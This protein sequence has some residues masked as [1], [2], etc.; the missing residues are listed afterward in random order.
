MSKQKTI[1]LV[2]LAL[3]ASL[4]VSVYIYFRPGKVNREVQDSQGSVKESFSKDE[5]KADVLYED[6]VVGFSMQHPASITIED[7]TPE[8]GLFYTL[9]S[10]NRED[11]MMTVAFKKTEYESVVEMLE[12]D[13]EAPQE[14][15]LIGATS[16]DGIPANQYS[17][18]FKGRDTLL[19]AAIDEGVLFL[20]EGPKD[21]GFWEETQNIVVSTFAFDKNQPSSTS[22]SGQPVIYEAE[23]VI[24]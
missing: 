17:Y 21:E 4:G 9:L 12:K 2:A 14:T 13:P 23:E 19:S 10:L 24:E 1:I 7:I 16:L 3:V 6:S 22:G 11:E 15:S 18:L 20:F 8:E 5:A